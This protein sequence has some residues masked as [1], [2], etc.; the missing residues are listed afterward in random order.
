VA[1]RPYISSEIQVRIGEKIKY[2]RIKAGY[3][4]Y[5]NFAIENEIDRKQYWRAE[6]GANLTI[7]SLTKILNIHKVNLEE[8]FKGL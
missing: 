2:L 3:T 8:F 4:S 5:E 7:N 1:N 6:N